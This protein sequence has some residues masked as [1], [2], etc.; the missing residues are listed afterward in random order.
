MYKLKLFA[1]TTH[2]L[3]IAIVCG[4]HLCK[5]GFDVLCIILILMFFVVRLFYNAAY[6]QYLNKQQ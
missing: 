1:I 3:G 4:N 2:E 5:N 6:K